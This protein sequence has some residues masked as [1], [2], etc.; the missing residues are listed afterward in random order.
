MEMPLLRAIGEQAAI[1]K[2]PLAVHTGDSRD[3]A[4]AIEVG[5]T[6]I[7]HGSFR[8]RIPDAL[9]SEMKK[10]GVFYDPTLSV[11]D[12]FTDLHAGRLD[13][14]E[15]TLVQQ[16]APPGMLAATRKAFQG[17]TSRAPGENPT[18]MEIAMDNLKRAWQSGVSLVTGTDSGNPLLIHGPAIHRE[19]QLWVKAGLPAET[20]LRAATY[21]AAR[22]LGVSNRIGLVKAGYEASLLLVDGNPMQDV[23]AT[24][25]ISA[26]YF[27]G[28]R[29]D[30]QGLFDQK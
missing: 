16:V 23:T 3:I 7:E 19:L 21:N 29:M 12:A 30:R 25:R 28:E 14:L 13:L 26:V 24:E 20:A 27:K 6:A 1:D 4:E 15:R 11:V 10:R 8:E 22:L 18:E 9:F 5:A 17:H 2:L